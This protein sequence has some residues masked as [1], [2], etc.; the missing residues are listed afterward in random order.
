VKEDY[1]GWLIELVPQQKGYE[2]WCWTAGGR[3]GVS[4]RKTYTTPG[5][6][7]MI[8]R[9]R[10]DLESVRWSLMRFLND[11]CLRYKLNLE[12]LS[13][14]ER[15][16]QNFIAV[17]CKDDHPMLNITEF[18]TLQATSEI[19]CAYRNAT[20]QTQVARIANISGWY[21]ERV[22]FAGEHLLFQALPEAELEIHAGTAMGAVMVNKIP[23]IQLQVRQPSHLA[24]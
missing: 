17:A 15:S 23:C 11:A 21:F 3:I 16:I 5:R 10:A 7:L 4:D 24:D 20:P 18:P 22:V 19:L 14:L 1:H 13:A 9:R 12:E 6:A 8:A 2:F